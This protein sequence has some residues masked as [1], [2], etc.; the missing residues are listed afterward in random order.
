MAERGGGNTEKSYHGHGTI[1]RDKANEIGAKLG[2]GLVRA[3]RKDGKDRD[4][5]ICTIW[6]NA[7]RPVEY[8]LGAYVPF[9]G[10][11]KKPKKGLSVPL[12]VEEAV[13]VLRE[14]FDVEVLCRRLRSS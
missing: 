2:L 5:P 12:D 1:F 6:P 4:L 11:S 7:L 13:A 14:H 3:N 8:Y 9:S 10:D